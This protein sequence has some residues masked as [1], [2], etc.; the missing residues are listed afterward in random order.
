MN[1]DILLKHRL[2]GLIRSSE[3]SPPLKPS[4]PL[5]LRRVRCFL[6]KR[7]FR[8]D[9][10]NSNGTR[11]PY[12]E[13]VETTQKLIQERNLELILNYSALNLNL[14]RFCLACVC[15]RRRGEVRVLYGGYPRIGS[16]TSLATVV[17]ISAPWK[18]SISRLCH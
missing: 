8:Y 10:Y 12:H 15:Q 5:P 14:L 4:R 7:N 16:K 3:A 13:H 18:F 1:K 11:R 17:R 2:I 9:R 6:S